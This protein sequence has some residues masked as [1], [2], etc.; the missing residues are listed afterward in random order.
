MKLTSKIIPL[1]LVMAF[2]FIPLSTA[3]AEGLVFDG[4]VIF[5]QDYTLENGNTLEGDLLV[6]G[7]SAEI[8]AGAKVNGDIILLGGTLTVDGKVSGDVS[9]TGGEVV[10]G[11]AAHIY[12][13][14]ITVGATLEKA[15]TAQVDG[16][17][18]NTATS[19]VGG[20]NVEQPQIPDVPLPDTSPDIH[21]NFNPFGAIGNLLGQA[22][23]L[24]VLAMVVMLFLARHAD[25]IA[26]AVIA[27]PLTAAGLGLLTCALAPVAFVALG[28]LSIFIITLILTVPLI[29]VLAIALGMAAIFGWIALGYEIGQRLTKA[30]HQEWH[31]A[32]SAGLGTFLL[33]LVVN[34]ASVLNFIPGVACFTWIL[35]SIVGMVA[36]GG[37]VMTRFGTQA[38]EAPGAAAPAVTLPEAA[39]TDK[40]E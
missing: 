38:V 4:R 16:Q 40:T 37:V 33:T 28:I 25:R 15:G 8:E 26:H 19:W 2:L 7:G 24:A 20:N 10:L 6:F 30:L 22:F 18:Y 1:F 27:Q 9:V 35:P 3:S 21:F 31:P 34:G 36:L 14:L 23:G 32:L 17:I 13:D 5:G 12:G 29:I 39:P 11:P